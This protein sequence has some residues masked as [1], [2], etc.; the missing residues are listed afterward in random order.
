MLALVG[1]VFVLKYGARVS[2]LGA[3][4]GALTFP[5]VYV[6]GLRIVERLARRSSP[7]AATRLAG[8][9][10]A[11]L[12]LTAVAWAVV[13]PE[14][15]RVAREPAIAAWLGALRAGDFP[16]CLPIRPSAFPGLFF[17]LA[18]LHLAGLA[19]WVPVA[20]VVLFVMVLWRL[21]PGSGGRAVALAACLALPSVHYEG[22]VRSELFLNAALALAAIAVAERARAARGVGFTIAAGAL[23]GLAASTRLIIPLAMLVYLAWAFRAARGRAALAGGI[24]V[25]VFA[26]L[27]A[28][29]VAWDAGRFLNCGPIAVQGLYL[30]VAVPAIALVAAGALGWTAADLRAV[31]ARTG[32]LTLALVAAGFVFKATS[33]GIPHA[34]WGDGFDVSYLVLATPWLVLGM[35]PR[36]ER[37]QAVGDRG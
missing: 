13:G 11:C 20:G 35:A 12:L 3:W 19:E 14:T 6:G 21:V 8:A 26:A 17:L 5:A 30:P 2:P 37:G 24:A 29:F 28:P 22:L 15:S 25:V 36:M 7:A 23:A 9:L 18:P 27:A 4:V 16:Y 33:V 31:F 32:L 34:L 10:A 1:S